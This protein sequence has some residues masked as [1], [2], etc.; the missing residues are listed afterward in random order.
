M[1]QRSCR[2]FVFALSAAPIDPS[3]NSFGSNL[4]FHVRCFYLLG[5]GRLGV[6]EGLICLGYGVLFVEQGSSF[7][8]GGSLWS[9]RRK[10]PPPHPSQ[11]AYLQDPAFNPDGRRRSQ[12]DTAPSTEHRT[13]QH[14]TQRAH[15]TAQPMRHWVCALGISCIRA[16][17]L[18]IT[19]KTS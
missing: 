3:A 17:L 18:S 13:Q 4:L 6:R 9:K 14:R 5:D 12:A 2:H 19:R 16:A 8:L 11:S 10:G 1:D 15:T 7:F